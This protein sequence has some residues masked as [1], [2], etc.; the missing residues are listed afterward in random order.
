MDAAGASLMRVTSSV[1]RCAAAVSLA[2]LLAAHVGS[3]DVYYSGKA[4][5][6]A[7]DVAIRPPKVVPGI[8]EV[9]VHVR[10]SS[11][12]RVVVRP[13]FWRAGTKGAPTGD[14]ARSVAGSPG[15]F[16]GELW[17]MATGAYSVNVTVTGPAGS[18]T[19]VVPVAS[20]ATGQLALSPLLRW[21]LG[22]LGTLLVAGVITAIHAAAGESQVE[23]GETTPPERTRRARNAAILAVPAMAFIILGGANWWNA[24]AMRYRRSLY[25]PVKT[26]TTIADV[27][28]VPT[29]TMA[30]T[31]ERWRNGGETPIMPDHG[32]LA[33]M[34][35]AR[36]D[37]PF[38]FA[39][40]H[41]EMPDHNTLVTSLPPLPSGRYRVYTDLVHETGFQRTLTDSFT[42]R[43]PL[44]ARG[45]GKL[46]A[47][48]AWS[49]DVATRVERSM[50]LSAHGDSL[51]IG[52][53]GNIHPSANETN[54]LRF[55]LWEKNG[56]SAMIEPYLGMYGHAVV[57]KDDGSVFV[58]LH[59]NGTSSMA[60]Q[61]AF[62]LR[63]HGDTT[64]AGRLKLDAAPMSDMASPSPL[65]EIS[66]PYAFPSAGRYRVWVQVRVGG[67]VHTSGYDVLVA[68]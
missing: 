43:T 62:A 4:G 32:K 47:D 63:D 26:T 34:F 42:L 55:S 66:F 31:E 54:V 6:Y 3:P 13:V 33:H 8:A 5:P 36:V 64:R 57:M 2:L 53:R 21:L 37:S 56:Q 41:P 17:L 20:V 35:L 51:F 18:G 40:L 27:E 15:S 65:K 9:H 49:A 7:V 38:V 52:W 1:A 22:L 68:P 16:T 59:P 30:I 23:P 45:L 48:D 50:L 12:S 61:L 44:D 11:V 58:H 60:S 24:E 14:E 29:L 67:V 19:V 25:R 39:H 28:G 46:T 10:D